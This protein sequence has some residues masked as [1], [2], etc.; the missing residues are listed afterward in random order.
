[1][2][3]LMNMI[4]IINSF[5]ND[6]LGCIHFLEFDEGPQINMDEQIFLW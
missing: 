2:I 3:V 1:M 4:F 5:S 6:N